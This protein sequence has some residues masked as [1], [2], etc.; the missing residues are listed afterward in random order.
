M[1]AGISSVVKVDD[2]TQMSAL[3]AKVAKYEY[4]NPNADKLEALLAKAKI[5]WV[6]N[7]TSSSLTPSEMR[8]RFKKGFIDKMAL[9]R[10]QS[11][12][13]VSNG[14]NPSL[15]TTTV[16][17]VAETGET[18]M[19]NSTITCEISRNDDGSFYI[20]KLKQV[21]YPTRLN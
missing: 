13:L 9:S 11:L 6:I 20:S 3:L 2:A 4:Q 8:E 17:T 1:T 7:G 5:K 21:Y 12:T 14:N 16:Q 15:Q 10:L 19:V 18:F